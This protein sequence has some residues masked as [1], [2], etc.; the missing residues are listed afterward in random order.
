FEIV[1]VSLDNDHAKWA[2]SVKTLGITWP[3]MSDLQGWK[4]SAA[5]VYGIRSI[6]STILFGPD[7]RVV[8]ADLRGDE[9]QHKLAEIYGE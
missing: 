3:Q 2:E 4:S 6:P 9:L 8:A 5:D 1:G 7:G